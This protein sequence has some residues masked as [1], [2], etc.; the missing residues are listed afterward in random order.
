ML[1]KYLQ[2]RGVLFPNLFNH[3]QMHKTHF[4]LKYTFQN[5]ALW[6]CIRIWLSLQNS[7]LKFSIYVKKPLEGQMSKTVP[8]TLAEY[9]SY[10]KMPHT[11]DF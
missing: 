4:Q 1:W 7:Y 6:K 10:I 3:C 8:K 2:R 9:T 5:Q 11:E